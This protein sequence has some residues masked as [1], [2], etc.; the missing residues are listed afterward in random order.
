MGTAAKRRTTES[1]GGFAWALCVYGGSMRYALR[2]QNG[3][4]V[5]LTDGDEARNSIC[6]L[7][8]SLE[9]RY[10]RRTVVELRAVRD[11]HGG[12]EEARVAI[13]GD[14]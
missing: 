9:L 4:T 11:R 7:S 13:E 3:K 2:Y 10:S 5:H 1:L 14:A 8:C 6:G 12:A